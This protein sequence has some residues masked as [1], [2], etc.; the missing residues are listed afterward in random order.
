MR[1]ATGAPMGYFLEGKCGQRAELTTLSPSC[2]NGLEILGASSSWKP[3]GLCW[4][5]YGLLYYLCIQYQTELY[6]RSSHM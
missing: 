3:K 4:T 5:E 6:V 1:K 2:A